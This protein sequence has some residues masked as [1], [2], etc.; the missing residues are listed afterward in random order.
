[1]NNF[2]TETLAASHKLAT[3]TVSVWSGLPTQGEQPQ[4]ILGEVVT[5]GATPTLLETMLFQIGIAIIDG[6]KRTGGRTCTYTEVT[7]H[8]E[9]QIG[10]MSTSSLPTA[11]TAGP[12]DQGQR[13]SIPIMAG[14]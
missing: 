3:A 8:G 11:A 14:V 9:S 6:S 4:V 7:L 5:A 1:M 12:R 13:R 2:T 10:V